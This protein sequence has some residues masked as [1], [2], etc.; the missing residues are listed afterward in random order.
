M[1]SRFW[2]VL[3]LLIAVHPR[4]AGAEPVRVIANGTTIWS[5]ESIPNILTV[6]K[7]GTILRTR[8]RHDDWFVVALPND[9]TRQ[10]QILA[11]L[12]EPVSEEEASAPPP[13]K[14][15]R[16]KPPISP[17]P[18][19]ARTSTAARSSVPAAAPAPA[20]APAAER[21]TPPVP[22]PGSALESLNSARELYASAAYEESLAVLKRLGKTSVPAIDRQANQYRVVCLYVLGR[23]GE[24][25]TIAELMIRTDPL[26]GLDDNEVSPR[27][28]AM[29]TAVRRRLLPDMIRDEMQAVKS[30]RDAKDLKAVETHLTSASAMLQSG[31][32][33]GALNPALLDLRGP[34]DLLLELTRAQIDTSAKTKK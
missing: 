20:P 2:P 26:T 6:V 23:P 19:D 29:F 21:A 15:L 9:P 10:G 30:A 11:R 7:A 13:R 1:T 12:V 32:E 3:A 17:A 25:E 31:A 33:I 34:I 22:S 8:I 5:L 16:A 27:V 14:P 24:A 18:I 4:V 28:Q